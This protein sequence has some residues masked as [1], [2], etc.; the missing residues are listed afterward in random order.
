MARKK[1]Y[2]AT[3]FLIRV[4]RADFSAFLDLIREIDMK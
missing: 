2:A 3:F 4:T 1:Y